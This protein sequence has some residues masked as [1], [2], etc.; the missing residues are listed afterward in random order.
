L[1]SDAAAE[2]E[3]QEQ[4]QQLQQRQDGTGLAV[5]PPTCLCVGRAAH[6]SR[7]NQSKK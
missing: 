5:H 6:S 2:Q 4:L 7:F 1:G 3:Q